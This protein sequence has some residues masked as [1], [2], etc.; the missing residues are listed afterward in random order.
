[1]KANR[2]K[3]LETA[4]WKVGWAKEFLGLSDEEAAFL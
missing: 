1:M 4:G 2:R 3:K